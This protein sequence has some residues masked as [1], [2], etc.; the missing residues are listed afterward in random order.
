MAFLRCKMCGGDLEVH[1]GMSFCTCE[2]CGT[3]QTIPTVKDEGLQTLFNRANVLRMKSEFDKAAEIY[4]K[5]LQRSESE[6]EA[7]WGLILCKYGIEYVED[8]K[9]FNRV[10]T[11]HRASYDA[12]TADEDYKNALKYADVVQRRIY[13]SEAAA[14]D[15]IQKGIIAL[16]LKEDPYDVFIC[17]KETDENGA[18]TQD[19]VIAN[20][21]YYQLKMEGF[22]VFYA[23]I[24]LEDKLGSEY[25]PYIF[26]ALNTSKVMLALGT[27]P[28]YF[29]LC[30]GEE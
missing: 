29:R 26:S 10:P 2:F 7:Y 30:L 11:C 8:P 14:I 15:E 24:S 9:T 22:K 23:A 19:S 21:I 12:V 13:E 18:R 1:E 27:K 20:D 5:I 17:Y 4:E 25:E 3:K 28:E 6:A 16:A